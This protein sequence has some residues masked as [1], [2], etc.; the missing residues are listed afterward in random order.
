[1]KKKTSGSKPNRIEYGKT[2]SGS[3]QISFV[4]GSES[5][6]SEAIFQNS[7]NFTYSEKDFLLLRLFQVHAGLKLD[8]PEELTAI[9]QIEA[10]LHFFN[11]YVLKVE[12]KPLKGNTKAFK[13]AIEFNDRAEEQRE[14]IE[15]TIKEIIETPIIKQTIEVAIVLPKKQG[16]LNFEPPQ[17]KQHKQSRSNMRGLAKIVGRDT[18]QT[19]LFSLPLEEL[20]HALEQAPKDQNGLPYKEKLSKKVAVLSFQLF[21]EYQLAEKDEDGFIYIEDLG[22]LAEELETNTKEL[23]YYLLY[24]GGYQYPR[25]TFYED[26]KEIGFQLA[27]LFDIE[28][29]YTRKYEKSEKKIKAEIGSKTIQLLI[30]TPIKRI[31]IKPSQQFIKD[32]E[33]K[34]GRALGYI[35]V[36]DNF[37]KLC[38][39]LSDYAFKLLS[40]MATNKPN[41]KISED[42]LFKHLGLEDQVK[43]QGLPRIREKI[44]EAFEELLEQK[45]LN[46]YE[47]T[48]NEKELYSYSYTYTDKYVNHQETN[49]KEQ[50]GVEYIDFNDESIGIEI[51]KKAYKAW[52]IN[53]KGATPAEASRSVAKKFNKAKS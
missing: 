6:A 26:E 36:N 47:L 43:K 7:I 44:I 16:L 30:N 19:T 1:M 27:K 46:K 17:I 25:V 38:L 45:H 23:K 28:F 15:K 24:L 53:N 40:Y 42:K 37:I 32:I 29:R 14:F 50:Q 33:G 52:L 4:Y 21:K 34:S 9:Q 12:F 18:S 8:K 10:A 20:Q 3:L 39:G 35:N 13:Y 51:R 22:K 49:K 48:K 31:R 5:E 41:Y 2:E 11:N